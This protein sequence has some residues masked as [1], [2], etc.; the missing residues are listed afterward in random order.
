M[1]CTFAGTSRDDRDRNIGSSTGDDVICGGAGAD[2]FSGGKGDDAL[3]GLA[4][5][6]GLPGTVPN[7]AS[8]TSATADPNP[9]NN[10]SAASLT[11]APGRDRG[12]DIDGD[13]G[14][15]RLTGA[16]GVDD[17]NGGAG[18]D[19]LDG[20]AGDDALNGGGGTDELDG[21]RGRDILKGGAGADTIDANDG[22]GDTVDCGGHSR[23]KATV[24][25]R[26]RVEN[27]ETVRRR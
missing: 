16:A 13:A 12:D 1:A 6:K 4:P 5:L 20:G 2:T 22:T 21:G 24:D 23:D 15:D 19:S 27:C 9:A 11:V 18:A 3:Y 7:A 14:D 26:D 10:T 8:V 17:L 25:R